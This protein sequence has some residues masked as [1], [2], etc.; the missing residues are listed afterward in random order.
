MSTR[1]RPAR[2]DV[3][4]APGSPPIAPCSASVSPSGS[5]DNRP[6]HVRLPSGVPQ[7]QVVRYWRGR[8]SSQRQP[9]AQPTEPKADSDSHDARHDPL[10]PEV[11]YGH[12][13]ELQARASALLVAP[14]RHPRYK[15]VNASLSTWAHTAS[16]VGAPSG[17]PKRC[18]FAHAAAH[19]VGAA[20]SS[21]GGGSGA[22]GQANR[23]APSRT[24]TD[25]TWSS[26]RSGRRDPTQ[27]AATPRWRRSGRRRPIGGPRS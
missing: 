17:Q 24:I 27:T 23:N 20:A 11:H 10:T 16:Q 22:G 5:R 6:D 18:R 25:F 9:H 3:R 1:S 7:A 2:Q 4:G 19:V 21:V 8:L 12:T 15:S 26:T 14:A 13:T